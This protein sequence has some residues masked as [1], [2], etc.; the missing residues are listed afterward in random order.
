MNDAAELLSRYAK[1]GE[2]EAFR[3]LVEVHL[4]LVF[5]AALR[6]LNGDQ[7]AAQDVAQTVFSDL[8]RKA[9]FLPGNIIL[10]GW[11]YRHTCLKAAEFV[12]AETRRRAR[13]KTAADMNALNISDESIWREVAPVVDHAMQQ[14][15]ETDRDAL[16]LRFFQNASLRAVSDALRISEDAAQKR[17]ARALDKLRTQLSR[18]G[19]TCT[20]A[21]LVPA[22]SA[23]AASNVPAGM[24]AS[25]STTALATAAAGQSVS[26]ILLTLAIMKTKTLIIGALVLGASTALFLQQRQ[27]S[28]LHEQLSAAMVSSRQPGSS[29]QTSETSPAQSARVTSDTGTLAAAPAIPPSTASDVLTRARQMI[30]GKVGLRS[31]EYAR[32]MDTLRQLPPGEI[33][34]ALRTVMQLS[35]A[36]QRRWLSEGLVSVWAET[37]GRAA[38]DWL[39]KNLPLDAQRRRLPE[40]VSCWASQDPGAAL[41]WLRE[42]NANQDYGPNL[43]SS[44]RQAL[45]EELAEGMS[46]EHFDQAI[47]LW[48]SLTN[49]GEKGSVFRGMMRHTG[50]QAGLQRIADFLA[51]TPDSNAKRDAQSLFTSTFAFMDTV[52]AAKYVEGFANPRDRASLAASVGERWMETDPDAAVSWWLNQATDQ[53]RGGIME[54]IAMSWAT[55]HPTRTAEWLNQ[56]TPGSDR[57]RA[58]SAF[59]MGIANRYP[60]KALE[61]AESIGDPAKRDDGVLRAYRIWQ[62][63]N[64]AAAQQY[65]S[66]AG[67]SPDRIAKLKNN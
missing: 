63:Q 11:L 23:N 31:R 4:G 20:A 24:A 21:A 32:L 54:R 64:P 15:S 65:L 7:H 47:S 10:S 45:F 53:T 35:D 29:S 2:E 36:D 50:T 1:T 12:R 66:S 26:S 48:N 19:V 33:P 28:K 59:A 8:A 37:D 49:D 27:I 57:D 13:E 17:I 40:I 41:S 3:Q 39:L 58:V 51:Q 42:F 46:I 5:S 56:A 6:K 16:V 61:W 43:P 62:Q 25:L 18:Q 52:G 22:L 55:Q 67:W 44:F 34:A 60:E 9:K 14:L 30:G 38:I